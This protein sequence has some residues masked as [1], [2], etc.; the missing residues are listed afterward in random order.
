MFRYAITIFLSAFL[1]FQ[2]QPMIARFILPWFG[3]TAAVWTT[4]MMFFQ[5]VLLLGYLYAHLL[6]R[7]FSPRTSW[8][9]HTIVLAGAA[10]FAQ[11]VP[12]ESWKPLG[13]E[14]LNW[15]I[16]TVLTISI[17]FPFFVLSSTGPLIQA[18]QSTSH[19]RRSP[20]RLYALSNLGSMLALISYPFLIERF[21]PLIQ[22]A[23]IWSIGFLIFTGFCCWSGW[24]TVRIG[25]WG[26]LL[27]SAETE[28]PGSVVKSMDAFGRLKPLVWVLLSMAASVML[29]ATTNL[30]CQEVAAVPFLW[31][32][33][34]SLYLLS[35]IV[36]FDRPALYRRRIFTP[37]L[38]V[39]T[40]VALL[41]FHLSVFA[42]ILLQVASLATVCFA[43]SMTCHG[44]LE[45]LKPQVNN[46][47]SFY[48]FVAVGG[49]LGGIFTA[50]VAPHL[51]TGFYEFHAALLI[52]LLVPLLIL[53][54][55]VRRR[56]ASR[57]FRWA[58][59]GLGFSIVVA[60]T[61][62]GCSLWYFLDSSFHPG[63]VY[64]VRNEYGLVSVRDDKNNRV[65]I[66]GRIAHGGQLKDPERALEHNS[67][68]VP[69]SGV[70]IAIQSYRDFLN[71]NKVSTRAAGRDFGFGSWWH[72][73]LVRGWG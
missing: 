2:V 8:L 71:K 25:N 39:S 58:A 17:G 44:E 5:F 22:Q 19:P 30:M 32:L 11:I 48:L 69:G 33:P 3:G 14:N 62:V 73:H 49:S 16:L 40:V 46:L 65:F 52:C 61:L 13:D 56:S 6:R 10:C 29:L 4:C 27:A 59:W 67:Y 42:G 64:Q 9:I 12:A 72:D 50:V 55:D 57:G 70:L 26:G 60:A 20:Y 51:F 28:T 18:W 68:Y 15:A 53:I 66:N 37:L 1:L 34:L 41:V 23:R 35:F 36:C 47:T 7:A 21:L 43:A 24:Q 38:V 31:I 54:R 63:L 45:R